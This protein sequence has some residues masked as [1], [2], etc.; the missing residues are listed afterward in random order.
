MFYL[1]ISKVTLIRLQKTTYGFRVK[2]MAKVFGDFMTVQICRTTWKE[3]CLKQIYLTNF[4]WDM[5][6]TNSNSGMDRQNSQIAS[7][8]NTEFTRFFWNTWKYKQFPKGLFFFLI[9]Q[10]CPYLF[11]FTFFFQN[12]TLLN[13]GS[14]L[15]FYSKCTVDV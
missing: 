4:I 3:I 8:V 15:W 2:K 10:N 5:L 14:N 6:L 1:N 13:D 11:A 12:R 9:I 7:Y